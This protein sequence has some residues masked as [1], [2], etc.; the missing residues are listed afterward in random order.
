MLGIL[1]MQYCSIIAHESVEQYGKRL[2]QPPWH[3]AIQLKFWDEGQAMVLEKMVITG[4][5]IPQENS[6][7]FLMR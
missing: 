1:S 2:S 6:F 4:S 3:G 7:H 5:M